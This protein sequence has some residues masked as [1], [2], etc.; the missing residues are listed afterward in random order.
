[1]VNTIEQLSEMDGLLSGK[2]IS[3]DMVKQAEQEIGVDFSE[4]YKTYLFNYGIAAVNGHELTGLGSSERVN[5]VLV[6]QEIR[7]R[8]EVPP[9]DMYVVENDNIDGVIYWQDT[10]GTIYMSINQSEPRPVAHSLMEF[11]NK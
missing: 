4:D 9:M 10:T 7:N 8:F 5:V 11:I 2:G 3:K 1:M 6:T